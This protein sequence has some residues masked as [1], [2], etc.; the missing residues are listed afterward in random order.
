MPSIRKNIRNLATK[1]F[2]ELKA[3]IKVHAEEYVPSE[4]DI[5]EERWRQD[6]MKFKQH[7]RR[8]RRRQI[9]GSYAHPTGIQHDVEQGGVHERAQRPGRIPL[10]QLISNS[11]STTAR[12]EEGPMSDQATLRPSSELAGRLEED[13]RRKTDNEDDLVK[14]PFQGP[15]FDKTKDAENHADEYRQLIGAPS[16]VYSDSQS[17][18]THWWSEDEQVDTKVE[19]EDGFLLGEE[20]PGKQHVQKED[21]LGEWNDV[22]D[23]MRQR[24]DQL[25]KMES[26]RKIQEWMNDVDETQ[27][28]PT[29]P[30]RPGGV[31]E[32]V[33]SIRRRDIEGA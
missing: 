11:S 7:R 21:D 19:N 20:A 5:A 29:T 18:S 15:F 25:W 33:A 13:T 9:N 2:Q 32:R 8:Q 26:Q 6:R 17:D 1:A 23:E 10:S 14:S 27:P 12:G 3:E 28:R 30:H 22:E 16:S 24:E 4:E 31:M